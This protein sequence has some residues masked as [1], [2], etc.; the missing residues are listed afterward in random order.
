VR[1][2][3][4]VLLAPLVFNV[5]A[6]F[7]GHSVLFIQNINGNTW[8]N[9]RYGI[10][11]IPSF[12]IFAGYAFYR[13]K[14]MRPLL[15]GIV[16]FA[17]SMQLLNLDAVTLDD[18]RVG[19]SQKNVTQV[20]GWLSTHVNGK[21]GFVLISVASHDAIIFSSGLPM[22]RFI[23][24]GTGTYWLNATSEPDQWARWIVMRTNDINDQTF[25][26]VSKSGQLKKYTL[27]E[28][29]PFADIYEL[30]PEFVQYVKTE[31]VLGVQR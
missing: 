26:L 6:L 2:A 9:V 12:S 1:L 29:Y 23:H 20:S 22:S 13:L 19:S 17:L 10:M 14:L 25:A 21:K 18:G 31:P 16:A 28:S 8:F 4:T 7:F 30:K 11:M 15:F 3:S 5:I 27:V 24:E